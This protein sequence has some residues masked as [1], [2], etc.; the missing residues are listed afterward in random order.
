MV[1]GIFWKDRNVRQNC[2]QWGRMLSI[3]MFYPQ[4]NHRP[5][6]KV[7][8]GM[9]TGGSLL[10]CVS[11][12]IDRNWNVFTLFLLTFMVNTSSSISSK[13]QCYIYA[14]YRVHLH[15]LQNFYWQL[16]LVWRSSKLHGLW[17]YCHGVPVASVHNS[18]KCQSWKCSTMHSYAGEISSENNNDAVKS[19][20]M[21]MANKER[22]LLLN[23][24][25]AIE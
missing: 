13:W 9:S 12:S 24:C 5:H 18:L 3:K 2:S 15:R 17:F 11:L 8:M 16:F 21:E 6:N 10:L 22:S 19:G 25:W 1:P 7:Q 4:C 14:E 23:M 20:W